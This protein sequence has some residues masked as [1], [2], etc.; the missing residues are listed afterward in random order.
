MTAYHQL[1]RPHATAEK[2][3]EDKDRDFWMVFPDGVDDEAEIGIVPSDWH[4][5]Y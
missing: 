5:A 1:S 4:V 2:R 3:T